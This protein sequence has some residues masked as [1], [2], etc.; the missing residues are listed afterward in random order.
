MADGPA[1]R[2][3]APPYAPTLLAGL[4]G[5]V[6][7]TVGVSK[8]W[9]A[10]SANQRGLPTIHVSVTGADLVPLAG[11]L[12]VV[13]LAAFGAVIATRGMV[14]RG[15]G[16][17]IVL[18]SL[19]VLVSALRPGGAI[20]ALQEALSNKGWSGGDYSTSS[21]VWRWLVLAG[22]LVCAVA[23]AAT[24]T[25]GAGWSTMGRQYDAPTAAKAR[26][27]TRRESAHGNGEDL[28]EA[29]VWREIDQGRDPTQTG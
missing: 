6:T 17:L 21:P 13:V 5:A 3:Q 4:I 23:G 2:R 18:G 19:V 11:A 15:I 9:A 10:A 7:V 8:P 20:D 29:E 24:A 12:G 26:P 22:S 25:Y 1:A 14:R 28:T 27:A 16:V